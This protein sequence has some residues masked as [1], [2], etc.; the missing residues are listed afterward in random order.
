MA[1]QLNVSLA[2]TAD[3]GQAAQQIK[4]LQ[5]QLDNLTN[6]RSGAASQLGITKEIQQAINMTN[7]LKAALNSSLNANTGNLDLGKFHE[8]I[9]KSGLDLQ[10]LQKNFAALGPAGNQAFAGLAKSIATAEIP[11]RRTNQ[12]LTE[13]GTTLK[14]SIRWQLSSSIIH[15]FMGSVQTAWHYAQNLNESLNNI[16]IVTGQTTDQMAQFAEQANKAA[17]SLS[18]ST[19]SYTDAS[20]IYYQQG[21]TDEQVAERTATTIKLANVSRQSAKDVSDQLTAVWNNFDDG[22]RSLESYVDVMVKLGAKT[23][24]SSDEIATGLEKFAAVADTVG[25]SF[26]YAAAALATVTA[27]TRQSA[28]TVGTAFRTLF[29]RMEGL[30]LGETLDD[31]TDLNK[32]S[33]ALAD[34]GVN[35]KEANGDIKDMDTILDETAAKWQ[36]LSKDQQIALAQT[37]GGVRQ[38]TTFISLMDNWADMEKN[39]TTA[40]G[41]EGALQEQADIYAESWEAARKRVQA[42]LEGIYQ[43]LINDKAFIQINNAISTVIDSI[44]NMIDA[45]GG[46]DGLLLSIG[47]VVTKVFSQQIGKSIENMLY[48]IRMVFGKGKEELQKMQQDSIKTLMSSN[49]NRDSTGGAASYDAYA[50]MG[51]VAQEVFAIQSKLS[52]EQ[53]LGVQYLTQQHDAYAQ[54]VIDAGEALEAEEDATEA[55]ERRLSAMMKFKK[56]DKTQTNDYNKALNDLKFYNQQYTNLENA[57]KKIKTSIGQIDFQNPTKGVKQLQTVITS[58][59]NEATKSGLSLEQAFSKKGAKAIQAFEQSIEDGN[60]NIDIFKNHVNGLNEA[61]ENIFLKREG[62]ENQLVE[63]FKSMGWSAEEAKQMIDELGGHIEALAQKRK[64]LENANQNLV[65]S[66]ETLKQKFQE[67]ATATMPFGQAI[68]RLSSSLMAFGMIYQSVTGIIDTLNDDDLSFW[69]KFFAILPSISML[70]MGLTTIFNAENVVALQSVGAHTAAAVG[71][72]AAG[73]AAAGATGKVAAFGAVVKG[74]FNPLNL[75]IGL[76]VGL[77]VALASMSMNSPAGQLNAAKKSAEE[78]GEAAEIAKNKYDELKSTI[79]DYQTAR[80]GLDNLKAGTD[81]FKTAL[82]DANEKALDLIETLDLLKDSDY[83]IGPN[84]EIIIYS[85]SLTEKAKEKEAQAQNVNIAEAVHQNNVTDATSAVSESELYNTLDIIAS[86]RLMTGW[87]SEEAIQGLVSQISVDATLLNSD[88]LTETIATALGFDSSLFDIEAVDDE[89]RAL[90]QK[91]QK[92]GGLTDQNEVDRLDYL[93]SHGIGIS[94]TETQIQGQAEIVNSIIDNLG[95]LLKIAGQD[96]SDEITKN[97]NISNA[98]LRK[99]QLNDEF[100]SSSF[101]G[102]LLDKYNFDSYY[103]EYLNEI[104][105][106]DRVVSDLYSEIATLLGPDAQVSD[107]GVFYKDE[108]GNEKYVAQ[109]V[110]EAQQVLASLQATDEIVDGLVSD[111]SEL[112]VIDK[113]YATALSN[114][115]QGN[116]D[117]VAPEIMKALQQ[118]FLETGTFPDFM[119]IDSNKLIE[120]FG[121]DVFQQLYKT[122]EGWTAAAGVTATNFSKVITNFKQSK[123]SI[124]KLELGDEIDQ[125][126]FDTLDARLQGL[127][128]ETSDGFFRLTVDA[129]NLQL[130]LADLTLNNLTTEIQNSKQAL[131]EINTTY[132]NRSTNQDGVTAIDFANT[133]T[134][135]Q[136]SNNE[137]SFTNNWNQTKLTDF[138]SSVLG[139]DALVELEGLAGEELDAKI[140]ELT[141]AAIEFIQNI[142][143]GIDTAKAD[144]E[145]ITK[146]TLTAQAESSNVDIS[147]ENLENEISKYSNDAGN[148]DNPSYVVDHISNF[149]S[150]LGESGLSY[151]EVSK[152]ADA[153][154]NFTEEL[155]DSRDEAN[156]VALA[157]TK[158]QRGLSNLKKNF[159]TWK[160]SMNNVDKNLSTQAKMMDKDYAEAI[161]G[162]AD[163]L[164]D[165]FNVSKKAFDADF[166]ENNI[167]DIEKAMKGEQEGIDNLQAAL[168]KQQAIELGIDLNYDDL[169]DEF[170]NLESMIEQASQEEVEVGTSLNDT[171]FAAGL[172]SMMEAA[173]YSAQQISDVL[174]SIN[175]SPEVTWTR[176]DSPAE[177]SEAHQTG[178]VTVMRDLGSE[179]EEVP[180]ESAVQMFEGGQSIWVASINGDSTVKTAEMPIGGGGGGSSRGGG[181]GSKKADKP[182]LKKKDDE[183][184]RYHDIEQTL[185]D[186]ARAYDEVSD[187]TDR[188][189]GTEKVKNMKE[190]KKV[191][192]QELAAQRQYLKE[193]EAYEK[194]DK[195]KLN[196]VTSV[197]GKKGKAQYNDDGTLANYDKMNDQAVSYY[198]QLASG[199]ASLSSKQLKD[200]GIDTADIEND[201]GGIDNQKLADAWWEAYEKSRDQYEET[202]NLVEDKK[203]EINDKANEIQDLAL[204]IVEYNIQMKLDIDDENLELLDYY[205]SEIDD[206]AF[207]A[208]EAIRL[209]GEETERWLSKSET[210]QK[211]IKDVLANRVYDIGAAVTGKANDTKDNKKANKKA[212]NELISRVMSGTATAEDWSALSGVITEDEVALI[213]EYQQGLLEASQELNEMAD[214]VMDKAIEQFEAYNEKLDDTI[215]EYEHLTSVIDHYTNMLNILGKTAEGFDDTVLAELQQARL[216]VSIDNVAS[217]REAYELAKQQEAEALGQ[218]AEAEARGDTKAVEEQQRMYDEVHA[219]AQEA[220]E[221]FLQIWED[222]LQAAREKYEQAI[223]ASVKAYEEAVSGP[224]G[225]LE[226]FQQAFDWQQDMN[227][228]YIE[229]YQKIYELSKLNRD[230]NKQIDDTDNVKNKKLLRDF[231]KEINDLQKD[232]NKMSEYELQELQKRY[233]LKLAEMQL[234]EAQDA[235][236]TVRMVRDSENNW[237]YVYTADEDNLADAQQNYEDKLYALQDLN[238][239]TINDLQAGLIQMQQEYSQAY[240]DILLN[241]TLSEEERQ[242]RLD[243]LEEWRQEKFDYYNSQLGTALNNNQS[244]YENEWA[245]YSEMTGYKISDDN[246]FMDSFDETTLGILSGKTSQEKYFN[247]IGQAVSEMKGNVSGAIE[248]LKSDNERVMNAAGDSVKTFVENVK[249]NVSNKDNPDSVISQSAT[250][251]SEF[252]GIAS[253]AATQFTA[254]TN[255]VNGFFSNYNEKI[256][257]MVEDNKTLAAAIQAGLD[258]LRTPEPAEPTPA[259]TTTPAAE[260]KKPKTPAKTNTNTNKTKTLKVDDKVTV[261]KTARTFTR[262]GGNGVYMANFVPGSSFTVFAIDGNEVQIGIPGRGVTGWVRKTDLEG[263]ASG[264]YTGDWNNTDGKLAFLHQKELVLNKDDTENM[265]AIVSFVRDIAH[266]IDMNAMS[267]AAGPTSFGVASAVAGVSPGMTQQVEIN[268][269]FPDAT[270]AAEIRAAFDS[271]IET[272]AQF[273]NRKNY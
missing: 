212:G 19:L 1:K 200:M 30:S 147:N 27:A 233:E 39:L 179:P 263:F 23:A 130:A 86:R 3:T 139:Q 240:Q 25:L 175:Y 265:L 70:L 122:I 209:L 58:L 188:A 37:V 141:T 33:Q 12:L 237:S 93:S 172:V 190:Q 53:A 196:T 167:D 96:I 205:L 272:A 223:Q 227:D 112:N 245:K 11:M 164:G 97:D 132:Q 262:D 185:Q 195:K 61:L 146:S 241:D 56:V 34:V 140:N 162:V 222:S 76:V 82:F 260:P 152:N 78:A 214:K 79:S 45:L 191:L 13:M 103:T 127:F 99:A 138:I 28:D 41:S 224:F 44:G 261:K 125:A 74:L 62:T 166:I 207:Q 126:T 256:R 231:Q 232:G 8:S 29:A 151:E 51:R 83:S 267:Q 153:L 219:R 211:G 84:G 17:K 63:I 155:A 266:V 67:I 149:L 118:Q 68:S 252:A 160:T 249:N 271:L 216:Q 59:K 31:G 251:K 77:G 128:E 206:D 75:V 108:E 92:E 115:L 137:D 100:S 242:A 42:S 50:S 94:E 14:N 71:F 7:Q 142:I 154:Q 102:M 49:M 95:T 43:D 40:A 87:N 270:D 197:L 210:Y 159:D 253:E 194:K 225:D 124:D 198:N 250:V 111:A 199:T 4:Q 72:K 264:G 5:Q 6:I 183:R 9:T 201:D 48:S 236:E 110:E 98:I 238:T 57:S 109:G 113:E 184:K 104:Q 178:T 246:K 69:E 129:D 143:D 119:G 235:K 107:E 174:S 54:Q 228:D 243:A 259:P 202:R 106:S 133:L 230:I 180:V 89:Y 22:S 192:E 18:T 150:D 208:A 268:A 20:L 215:A 187:A 134:E 47:T 171:N 168:A 217:A 60:I 15:G 36:Q 81:E 131:K 46:L 26:D 255:S 114:L 21:L 204:D 145:A 2:F 55:V 120:I 177:F 220:E 189:F 66:E 38:Y 10:T 193:A 254:A 257:Q 80:S 247:D 136:K 144:S 116:A 258:L 148:T 64:S 88:N 158:M 173:G 170:G 135:F 91:M 176:Y 73:D 161:D 186:L 181:G 239:Q 234:E 218:I 221:N 269:Q 226:G 117:E 156:R 32:Y 90:L 213:Q 24:S 123:E 182:K 65:A 244:L 121:F 203:Q 35:I 273:A 101:Q 16:R 229:D 248:S 165:M 105:N 52:G 85:D 169:T 163:A 157:Y